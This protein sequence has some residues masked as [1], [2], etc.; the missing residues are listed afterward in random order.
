MRQNKSLETLVG[1]WTAEWTP[2]FSTEVKVSSRN[3]D[4][5]PK[6]NAYLPAMGLQFSG[7][8]PAGAPAGLATGNRFLN[9]GTEQSRQKNILGHQDQGFLRSRYLGAGRS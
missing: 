7:A 6:N 3:Y 2:T 4:S 1:Q 9:F 8:L 5:V